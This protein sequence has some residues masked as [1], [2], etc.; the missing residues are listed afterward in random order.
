V[1]PAETRARLLLDLRIEPGA[2]AMRL[3]RGQVR[4]LLIDDGFGDE[5]VESAL[6]GL[7]EVLM[8]ACTHGGAT[9]QQE[10]VEL[11]IELHADRVVFEVGDRGVYETKNGKGKAKLPADDSESGRGLFLIHRTMDEVRFEPREGG[12]TRVRLVKRR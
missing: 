1:A 5:Q 9:S 3:V 7:D 12:G 11:A 10:P 8:N 2:E 4:S 6:L